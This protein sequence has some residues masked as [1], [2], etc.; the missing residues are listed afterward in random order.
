MKKIVITGCTGMLGLALAKAALAN[1]L[2]VYGVVR[3]GSSREHVLPTDPRFHIV[4]C[5][6]AHISGLA[7]MVPGDMDVLYHFAW[8]HT[9]KGK[10]TDIKY[11]IDNIG[12]TIDALRAARQM[13]CKLFVGAG[14]QAEYGHMAP[15][16]TGPDAPTNP[17]I[18]YGVCKLAAG[19][20]AMIE[21]KKLGIPVVWPRIF[22]VYGPNDKRGTLID[23]LIRKMTN[24]EHIATTQ[25]IQDWDYL[26]CDDAAE[27]FLR[28]GECC[29]ES[30][31]YCLGSGEVHPLRYYIDE[32]K[33]VLGYEQK[34]G[35][36]EVPYNER[37]IMYLQADI[38]Q[39]TE[40]TGWMP[41]VSFL[42]GIRR[43]RI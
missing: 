17:I 4:Y 25:G 34:I 15:R 9:G 1:D 11:Q 24:G 29:R 14:S 28:I 30:K 37:S 13:G 6:L 23:E 33:D 18:A 10:E 26:Y 3:A 35:Y 31:V 12:Y 2:E 22:S 36:G 7:S 41:R 20:L 19:R 5:D 21:G 27:A 42:D 40:D 16:P 39:L 43:C 38:S 32:V 8:S